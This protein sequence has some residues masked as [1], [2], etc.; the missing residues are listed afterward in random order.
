MDSRRRK[1]EL[2][3]FRIRHLWWE[4]IEEEEDT[5]L[6]PE[7]QFQ[8]NMEKITSLEKETKS[9]GLILRDTRQVIR[10]SE[11]K[12]NLKNEKEAM[13]LARNVCLNSQFLVAELERRLE[14][15]DNL[16]RAKRVLLRKTAEVTAMRSTWE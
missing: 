16:N 8:L 14:E 13:T 2:S 7:L 10:I 15:I 3:A 6:E 1:E 5:P 9:S 12:L 4:I 11:E